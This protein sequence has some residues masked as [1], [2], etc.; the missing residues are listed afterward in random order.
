M[1]LSAACT[2]LSNAKE[3]DTEP[4]QDE[5]LAERFERW[6][7]SARYGGL[8][9]RIAIAR[10][11]RDSLI[12]QILDSDHGV[13]QKIDWPT[14]W[15]PVRERMLAKL[16][17][18]PGSR[19]GFVT[20][21]YEA[22]VE[23]PHFGRPSDGG[24]PRELEW[25]LF[26]L[27]RNY[28]WTSVLPDL[29]H[30]HLGDAA[31]EDYDVQVA[32]RGRPSSPIFEPDSAH[33]FTAAD[34]DASVN[35]FELRPEGFSRGRRGPPRF[36]SGGPDLGIPDDRPPQPPPNE[37]YRD[38]GG[39]W[40]LFLHHHAGSLESVVARTRMRNLTVGFAM[41]LL[42]LAAGIALVRFTRRAQKLA[43]LQLEFVAG[44]S[45][46]LRTPLS[47]M[48]T[49]GYNLQSSVANKA[50]RVRRYGALIQ[51][52][53]ER[54]SA[55]V[56]QVLQFSNA[57]AGRVIGVRSRIAVDRLVDDAIAAEHHVVQAFH[58]T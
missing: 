46:E 16:R 31:L 21:N 18:A 13:F 25:L 10:P 43:G 6:R 29:L 22:L 26:E 15:D 30:R 55:V 34:A 57:R 3:H 32:M 58:C 5:E 28:V 7:E 19:G 37:P 27:D 20:G 8:F 9:R 17:N 48:R 14:D 52:E 45:H 40:R 4:F 2:A 24:P 47:V 11:V 23:V 41:L 38:A 50:S 53:S 12:L 33:R 44:V 49:A 42:I 56:E 36:G 54:L 35:L 1:Q 39:R 51:Q